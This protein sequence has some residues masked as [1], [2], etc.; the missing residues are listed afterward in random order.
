[1]Q[2]LGELVTELY[3]ADGKKR[4]RLWKSAANLMAKMEVPADRIGHIVE[5]KDAT[6]LAK[7]V[8]E[9]SNRADPPKKSP[10]QQ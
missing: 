2:K 8:Q 10:G 4:D 7:L 1:L 6:L 9:W 5:N 3:L